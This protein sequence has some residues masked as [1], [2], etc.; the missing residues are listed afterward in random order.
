M[1]D[2]KN[3]WDSYFNGSSDAPDYTSDDATRQIPNNSEHL[4]DSFDSSVYDTSDTGPENFKINFDFDGVYRDVPTAKPLVRRREK[5]SG[6]VGGILYGI[7]IIC[8]SL[9]AAV[10]M[11]MAAVDVLAL[12]KEDEEIILTVPEDIF[13]AGTVE[14]EDEEGNVIGE[15]EAQLADLDKVAELMYDSGLIKYKGLFKIF[16]KFCDAESK[17]GPGTY[18][19]NTKYDYHALV[20]GTTPG[21]AQLVEVELTIPEGYT[22]KQIFALLTEEGVCTAEELWDTAANYNFEAEYDF[23]AGIPAKGDKYRLEGY[24]FPDTYRFYI[25]DEPVRVIEKFLD[26]FE[27]KF[28]DIYIERAAE[29]GYSIHDIIIIASMIERESSSYEGERDMIASVIFNRIDSSGFPYLQI[30]ATILYGMARNDDED[31]ELTTSYDSPYNSYTNEG[32]PPGP[33][34]N[35]GEAAIRGA[36]YP[37]DS[38][39]YYYA[40]HK[41]GY[42]EFFRYYDSFLSFINSE[43]YGG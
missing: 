22:I 29:V 6:C 39:Y 40:L 4:Q 5:R 11:W 12:G 9:I 16:C 37:E 34:S 24:M 25:G 15:E 35:P 31:L 23:L 28:G 2:N 38:N 13:Y 36:L 30:D 1:S 18:T 20:K 27:F 43:Y 26:N 19:L 3:A 17:V 10:L 42:H 7:F 14:V 32:L 41:D 8:V 21:S 33:I